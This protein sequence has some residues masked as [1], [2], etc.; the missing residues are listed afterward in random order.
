MFQRHLY[1]LILLFVTLCHGRAED[2]PTWQHDS[3]RTG[4]TGQ[5]LNVDALELDWTWQSSSPPQTAWAGPAKYDAYAFHRNLPSMRNY[6][7]VFHLIAVADKVWFGS[8]VDDSLYC[9]HVEDGRE[10]W[11]VTTDGPV[12]LAPT[13]SDGR[14]YFGS[15][16]G[17]ARCVDA[18]NGRLIWKF[19]PAKSNQRVLN[20]GR[21]IS[22]QPCRTGVVVDDDTA[23][24]GCAMLPWKDSFL[25]ALDAKTGTIKSPAHF[26]KTLPGRT[27]E[28]APALS[29]EALILPQGRVSPRVFDRNTGEDL[30]DMAKSG[31]GSVVVVTVDANVLHGPGTDSRKG[32][33]RRSN[34]KSREMVAALGR[35]NALVVDGDVSWMLTDDAIIV[36]SL[37]TQKVHWKAPCDC[38]FA[39]IK[40]GDTLFVGGDQKVAAYSATD[41]KPL[42]NRAAKGRVFGLVAA[43]ERLFAS[44]D[45][46]VIHC[47]ST[48][49]KPNATR[50][51]IKE[52]ATAVQ[53]DEHVTSVS[54]IDDNRLL[55]HWALQASSKVG[56]EIVALRGPNLTLANEGR[57]SR[58]GGHQALELDGKNDSAIVSPTFQRVPHPRNAFTAEAWVRIDQL[59]QW[60]GIIGIIQDNGSF[61]KGW[62]LGYRNDRF[63]LAVSSAGGPGKL[64]YLT[65]DEPF[66]LSRWYHVAGS[67]DGRTMRLF[68]DGRICAE[69]NQQSGEIAYPE[70]AWFEIG[71]YHDQ[72]EYFRMTGAIHETRLY[73][74][75][76]SPTEITQHFDQTKSRI[77]SSGKKVELASGP[78]LTFDD[79]KTAI[80]RWT[81]K[82]AQPTQLH[83][84]S[85]TFDQTFSDATAKTEH[86]AVLTGLDHNRVYQYR[87]AELHDEELQFTEAFECDNFFNYS[88]PAADRIQNVAGRSKDPMLDQLLAQ[89]NSRR[90]LCL[91]I[92][93]LDADVLTDL[94][95]RTEFRFVVAMIDRDDVDR[96]RSVLRTNCVYGNQVVVHHVADLNALPFPGNWANIVLAAGSAPTTDVI[97]E[98]QHQTRPDGGLT[99]VTCDSVE[100]IPAGFD[101]VANKDDIVVGR[102]VKPALFGSGDWSHLYASTDNSAFGGEQLA[103]AKS[104][105]DLEV[106]WVGRPG[107][108]YQA[109]RSGRKPSPL[110]IGG[111]LFLQGL[112]RIIAVDAFNGTIVWSLEIPGFERFNMPRDCSNWCGN[113]DYLFAAVRDECWKITTDTGEVVQRTAAAGDDFA[114]PM[115]WGYVATDG[116]RLYGSA[117]RQ[118][119]SWTSFWGGGDAGWYDARAGAVTFPVCSD[120]LFC[121]DAESLDVIWKYKRGL[122]LNPTITVHDDTLY[123]VESRS[124][125]VMTADERRVGD[126]DLWKELYLVAIDSYNGKQKWEQKLPSM[127]RQ[128]VFYLAHASQQLTLVS[129]SNKSYQVRSLDDHDGTAR[130]TQTMSWPGGKGDHGK[131][132]MRPAIVGDRIFLRPHVLSLSDGSLLPERM[133]PGHG[134]GTYACTTDAVIYRASTVTMWNPESKLKSTWPRLR[135]DCWLSTIPASGMLLSPEGGGGCSCGSWMETSIGFMPKAQRDKGKLDP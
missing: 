132:M 99:L 129:S 24:F 67:Y 85:S 29:S 117:V 74:H 7:S 127:E 115:D 35:G 126:V 75:S 17:F 58:L 31:G 56:H 83:F 52:K 104:S 95:R 96:A 94:C 27:M 15:D 112:N 12:R 73:S 93:A 124:S 120:E 82:L 109:D 45:T 53:Q 128:V 57:F 5:Q 114:F 49:A 48:T 123:F 37:A 111:R 65:A 23:W 19:S 81:S 86:R 61:E 84:G 68:V 77:P 72:D 60:G 38:P 30:G 14:I 122:V 16:D 78:W 64:T 90:G 11:V 26:V 76:L 118:G 6:D 1:L 100:K 44:S 88:A 70:Q 105:D 3:R 13:W 102:Y 36:S 106:Q 9:L 69:S 55:G 10:Q 51:A 108:R 62:L 28:G 101:T 134:C 80:V 42:W 119:T 79:P 39:M 21:L 133:P 46:G 121:R 34:S 98:A 4:A 107:P 66:E 87:I 103:G 63:C 89:L 92:G 20:N 40:A 97:R 125:K 130:W 71:A 25:C 59:Q 116:A 33:F 131:A 113:R 54:S 2:W 8:S 43:N 135:P 22:F 91:V 110:A 41:G 47:Y 32:G 18:N 50:H